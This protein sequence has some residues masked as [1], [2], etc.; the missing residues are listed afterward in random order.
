MTTAEGKDRRKSARQTHSSVGNSTK[1]KTKASN[2]T[3]ISTSTSKDDLKDGDG[4]MDVKREGSP[5]IWFRP[6]PTPGGHIQHYGWEHPAELEYC[7]PTDWTDTEII[8]HLIAH[9][10]DIPPK[11]S[12][13][14]PFFEVTGI[15]GS[16]TVIPSGYRIP[17]MFI[18]R[19]QWLSL[20]L[21]LSAEDRDA[22]WKEY[23][24]GILHVSRLCKRLLKVAQDALGGYD[25]ESG[26]K[27]K[28][29]GIDRKWRSQTFDRALARYK[30]KWFISEPEQLQEFW[31]TYKDDEYKKDPLKY[32]WR[33][34]AL[35]GHRGFSLTEDEIENGIS[36]QQLMS[37]LKVK[38]EKWFWDE[39]DSL[40]VGGTD[41]WDLRQVARL[42]A[43][44]ITPP[45]SPRSESPDGQSPTPSTPPLVTSESPKRPSKTA[46]VPNESIS[47]AKPSMPSA[48]APCTLGKRPGTPLEKVGGTK[49]QKIVANGASKK[50]TT[51]SVSIA[52]TSP[53]P[54][55]P[56]FS[57]ALPSTVPPRKPPPNLADV[58][59]VQEE[60]DRRE[61]ISP[62]ISKLPQS[63][64]PRRKS[65]VNS[66]STK[67]ATAP[68]PKLP[69]PPSTA[70]LPHQ[71]LVSGSGSNPTVTHP[72]SNGAKRVAPTM[73][74]SSQPSSPAEQP[75]EKTITALAQSRSATKATTTTSVTDSNTQV[76]SGTMNMLGLNL[77]SF[78]NTG[79]TG[80][81]TASPAP[82]PTTAPTPTPILTPLPNTAVPVKP[83][84]SSPVLT[85][86]SAAPGT[87]QTPNQDIVI[88][89]VE[90]LFG[91]F[92]ESMRKF[93]TELKNAREEG[94]REIKESLHTTVREEVATGVRSALERS[95]MGAGISASV[96]RAGAD[97]EIA[98]QRAVKAAVS[99]ELAGLG[100]VVEK[101][102]GNAV[103]PLLAEITRLSEDVNGSKQREETLLASVN[104]AREE[105]QRLREAG[106]GSNAA[107][108]S[109]SSTSILPAAG[110]EASQSLLGHPLAHLL[111]E[112]D[113]IMQVDDED[114]ET[115]LYGP[116]LTEKVNQNSLNIVTDAP[117]LNSD[118]SPSGTPMSM[119]PE[120]QFI[121]SESMEQKFH[122]TPP[123][124]EPEI[125]PHFPPTP[126]SPFNTDEIED[127]KPVVIGGRA[128]L[129]S[130]DG[131]DPTPLS[132][133]VPR[134]FRKKAVGV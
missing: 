132:A 126:L 24:Y 111:V 48:D 61:A 81:H 10:F 125:Q 52:N 94:V 121:G 80:G 7:T 12:K 51:T 43:R 33:R 128:F 5:V 131:E 98:V 18:A 117:P 42:S 11:V 46:P 82:T 68:V 50:T 122:P 32:D 79:A 41:A 114:D 91:G 60:P 112:P 6:T 89:A 23:K 107:G 34:W 78:P 21:V 92:A 64:S 54:S 13:G 22:E 104:A 116:R 102:V 14:T 83:T 15:D 31:D 40:T 73:R 30:L 66:G 39:R 127:V 72:P 106:S 47:Q 55:P 28:S 57:P 110:R 62:T 134:R 86:N 29:K 69:K 49:T 53:D 75:T 100:V 1:T 108:P 133:F 2:V 119:S 96:S 26:A 38:D 123:L 36:A 35:K 74:N 113:S 3:Q 95:N 25:A 101:E 87:N 65:S 27:S 70:P 44:S 67:P 99:T 88:R 120:I 118:R 76:A 103:L 84:S 129:P 19:F 97:L 63:D 20:K 37:G 4:S 8:H 93:S 56:P 124:T 16:R 77:R 17:L 85:K 71:R 9:S 59:H 115:F 105:I 90:S 58:K 109:T 130:A 45:P